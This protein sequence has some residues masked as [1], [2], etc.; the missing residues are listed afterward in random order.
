MKTNIYAVVKRYPC[1]LIAASLLLLL[2]GNAVASTNPTVIL[3]DRFSSSPAIEGATVTVKP[4]NPPDVPDC[5]VNDIDCFEI[6][7]VKYKKVA[8]DNTS[9]DPTA[10]NYSGTKFFR[11]TIEILTALVGQPIKFE[12]TAVRGSAREINAT[13]PGIDLIV[14]D[15]GKSDGRNRIAGTNFGGDLFNSIPFSRLTYDQWFNFLHRGQNPYDL[16]NQPGEGIELAN[17]ILSNKPYVDKDGNV[18][19]DGGQQ[20]AIPIVGST[21]QGSGHFQDPVTNLTQLC[22]SGWTI[23]YLAPAETILKEFA[24]PGVSGAS[25]TLGFYPA[26]GGQSVL[27]PLQAGLANGFEFVSPRGDSA[28]FLPDGSNTNGGTISDFQCSNDVNDPGC[29]TNMGQL[30]ANDSHYPSWHQPFLTT[31]LLIDNGQWNALSKMQ[32]T[33]IYKVAKF[34]LK[35]SFAATNSTQCDSLKSMLDFNNGI[36]QR[37]R[38]TGVL[39]SASADIEMTRWTPASLL[40][41]LGYAEDFFVDG[42]AKPFSNG[43]YFTTIFDTVNVHADVVDTPTGAALSTMDH[44]GL[45]PVNSSRFKFQGKKARRCPNL[46]RK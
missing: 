36:Q 9:T 4:V 10:D 7:G 38:E 40:A 32:K 8:N 20:H 5:T 37:D 22:E 33:I 42:K 12:Q 26:V 14:L 43:A 15:P 6:A 1:N 29:V 45:F 41:L 23:R 16:I 34:S 18:F 39:L 2:G 21:M 30:G 35:R 46:V 28:V 19:P 11:K 3:Y 17:S 24:C 31:W 25:T 27:K 13:R 44:H